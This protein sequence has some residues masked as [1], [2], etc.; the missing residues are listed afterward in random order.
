MFHRQFFTVCD[1]PNKFNSTDNSL[2]INVPFHLA[3][4]TLLMWFEPA[5]FQ[6]RFWPMQVLA[7]RNKRNFLIEKSILGRKW[8]T[9]KATFQSNFKF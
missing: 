6:K 8:T 5:D 4:M 2:Q 9:G 3:S 7:N 1:N